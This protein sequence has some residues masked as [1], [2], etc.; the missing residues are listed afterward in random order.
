MDLAEFFPEVQKFLFSLFFG[1]YVKIR[2]NR[3]KAEAKQV[4]KAE[5]DISATALFY[6]KADLA[7]SSKILTSCLTSGNFFFKK[8]CFW[9]H[10]SL[11]IIQKI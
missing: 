6:R 5:Q 10:Y 8:K 3:T 1:C 4:V 7:Y 11:W 2:W 9:S